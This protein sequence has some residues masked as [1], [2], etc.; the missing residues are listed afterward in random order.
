MMKTSDK[1]KLLYIISYALRSA[2]LL[3]ATGTI[4]QTFLSSIG[5]SADNIYI[6]TSLVGAVNVVVIL[7]FSRFADTLS[8]I[9]RT[10]LVIFS[11]AVLFLFY[12]P[13]C[14][15]NKASPFS[16]I[17]LLAVGCIQSVTTALHTVCDYKL[18]YYIFR[19]EEYGSIMAVCGILS[20]GISFGVGAV[21]TAACSKF[22]YGRIMIFAFTLSFLFA[23]AAAVLTLKLKNISSEEET[24]KLKTTSF[25]FKD[26]IKAVMKTPVFY[27]L[28]PANLLRGFSSGM[29]LVFTVIA[30]D[31]LGYTE[32]IT[33]LAVSVQAVTSLAACALFGVLSKHISPRISVFA[34]SLTFLLLPF[35]LI[36]DSPV[37]FLI[38]TGIIIFGRTLIDYAVPSVLLYAVP[39][40]IAGPYNA[41]RMILH[42]GGSLIATSV[43]ALIPP[44]IL[45][46]AATVFQLFSGTVFL[47]LPILRKA[48]PLKVKSKGD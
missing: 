48:S 39:S 42:N 5:M 36:P 27:K 41:Y 6:H 30:A 28:L 22:S 10:A 1:N 43:A 2:S 40:E 24:L 47:L 14:F 44:T 38:L 37:L 15:I 19:K 8:I 26:S 33:T 45:L 23:A 35:I 7:L 20:S 29:T 4:M 34:G 12:L 3:T 18:P 32:E 25:S 21:I 46:P 11:G 16:F 9:K 13:I 31:N 17:L